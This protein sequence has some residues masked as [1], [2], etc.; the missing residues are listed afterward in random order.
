MSELNYTR[1]P[2]DDWRAASAIVGENP[3]TGETIE[4]N[5]NGLSAALAVQSALA[6]LSAA[7]KAGHEPDF[8]EKIA[9]MVFAKMEVDPH[10]LCPMLTL[11]G[12]LLML[13]RGLGAVAFDKDGHVV[14][15]TPDDDDDEDIGGPA[16]VHDEE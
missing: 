10:C 5:I 8:L 14:F 11:F 13:T 15:K 2:N 9:L 12:M 1:C 6:T 16:C 4:V 3:Q 7:M